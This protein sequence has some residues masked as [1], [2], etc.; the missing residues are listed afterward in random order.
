MSKYTTG[1]EALAD[2][3][4]RAN[5][6]ESDYRELKRLV[7]QMVESRQKEPSKVVNA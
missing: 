4:K 6:L 1:R 7:D 5:Q 2:L 3:E